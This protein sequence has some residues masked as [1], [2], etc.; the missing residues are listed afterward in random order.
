MESS[1]NIWGS[2]DG[3][4]SGVKA[5]GKEVNYTPLYNYIENK[6]FLSIKD[7]DIDVKG[8]RIK[9]LNDPENDGDAVSKRYVDSKKSKCYIGYIPHNY[10]NYEFHITQNA[11]V[12]TSTGRTLLNLDDISIITFATNTYSIEILI[13]CPFP[14]N[15]WCIYFKCSNITIWPINFHVSI[16]GS[17]N[18]T[19]WIDIYSKVLITPL[20]HYTA[21]YISRHY[22]NPLILEENTKKIFFNIHTDLI[23]KYYKIFFNNN[24][25]LGEAV[26]GDR[27]IT[28][29]L[30]NMQLFIYND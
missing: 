25:P 20:D 19:D 23:F 16:S 29:R 27:F 22:P 3:V 7:D 26:S 17:N 12:H 5:K 6:N 14:V 30:S 28:L 10:E 24:T 2:R 21:E 15:V 18:N 8:S 13:N 9:N 1:I 11:T 4:V